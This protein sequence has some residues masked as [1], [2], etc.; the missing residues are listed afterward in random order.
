MKFPWRS[1]R[2]S[3]PR[4]L[5]AVLGGAAAVCSPACNGE[6]TSGDPNGD[7]GTGGGGGN[8]DGGLDLRGIIDRDAACASVRAEATLTKK[9]VDII[10]VI[11]NSGSMTEEIGGVEKN[12]N[13]NFATVLNQ[14]G[15]DYRVILISKHGLSSS[16]QSICI[17]PP[18]SGN[19]TCTPPPAKPTNGPR[20]FHYDTEVASTD[21]L[22]LILS[23]YNT[24]DVN[25]FTTKGWNEWLRPGAI[26]FF[27]EVTDDNSALASATFETSLFKLLPANFGTAA[28]RNYVFHTIAGLKENTPATTPWPSTAPLQTTKCTNGTGAVNTGSVYQELSRLTGGL[29]FP[30]CEYAN[31]NGI[32]QEL[33]KGVVAGATVA[34]DFV[35]P[36]APPGQQV[37]LDTVLV[38][39]TPGG[40]GAVQSLGKVAG[41]ATCAAGKFYILNN[42]ITLCPDTCKTVQAD[43]K[44]KLQVL[45]SCSTIVN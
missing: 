20:F 2:P 13:Q 18:L 27:L 7:G 31:F 25:G 30:I 43:T 21:S 12:I 10:V 34:C 19:A 4:M 39:Y 38:E 14:S 32:F 6:I 17:A 16:G 24:K 26:R 15:L 8:G 41:A 36:A 42:R 3:F 5:V 11:D 28:A 44:A 22:S 33:A 29:R 37:D 9:P 45:F 1:L 35:V 23:T 40:V